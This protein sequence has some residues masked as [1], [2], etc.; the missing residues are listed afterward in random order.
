MPTWW[1]SLATLERVGDTLNWLVA[2]MTVAAAITG[3]ATVKVS[4]RVAELRAAK[5]SEREAEVEDLKKV[6]G[7][8]ELSYG[9]HSVAFSGSSIAL[10]V[11][12]MP[13]KLT[14]LGQLSFS[15]KIDGPNNTEILGIEPVSGGGP[16][17]VGPESGKVWE[18][19]RI[20]TL[21]YSLVAVGRP[22]FQ[23]LLSGKCTVTIRG[24]HM[25]EELILDIRNPD[26][27]GS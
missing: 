26:T 1:S 12:L 3:V 27:S 20:A 13:S 24:S 22:T 21:T 11:Q 14:P 16:V 2:I 23:V 6:A 4:S 25:P 18:G 15:V 8:G 10:K 9:S 7:R 17:M 19:G 5:E